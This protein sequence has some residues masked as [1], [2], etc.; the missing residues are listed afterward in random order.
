M[1]IRPNYKFLILSSG[2]NYAV[3]NMDN[4]VVRIVE[5]THKARRCIVPRSALLSFTNFSFIYRVLESDPLTE[6]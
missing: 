1:L 6:L 4:L 5:E 2:I 3:Y